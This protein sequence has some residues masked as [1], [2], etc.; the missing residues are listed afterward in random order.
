MQEVRE[1]EKQNYEMSQD[2]PPLVSNEHII[3]IDL[4]D[5]INRQTY[6]TT[7]VVTGSDGVECLSAY[8]V[9]EGIM[10]QAKNFFLKCIY[11]TLIIMW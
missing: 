3:I 10:R 5:F 8:C 9:P 1:R 11:M 2:H 4:Q 7:S 6:G